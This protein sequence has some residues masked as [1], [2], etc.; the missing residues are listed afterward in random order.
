VG[1]ANAATA[2]LAAGNAGTSTA[3][4]DEEIHT[5]DTGGGIVL[6]TKIDVLL[7][8]ETEAAGLGE[9]LVEKL[10]LLDLETLLEDLLGLLTAN[11]HVTGDLF[12][13]ADGERTDGVASAREDRLLLGELLQHTGGAGQAIAGLTNANVQDELV[14]LDVSHGVLF[15]F[16]HLESVGVLS[17]GDILCRFYADS[18]RQHEDQEQSIR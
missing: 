7:D 3:Q 4:V 17:P 6:D 12:V 11:R 2:L 18:L 8:T 9:V 10:V 13:T 14:D 5:V 1:V 16:R 15:L